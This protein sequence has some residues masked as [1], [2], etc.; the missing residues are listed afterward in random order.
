LE[1]NPA[2]LVPRPETE[3]V[4]ESAL[5][6]VGGRFDLNGPLRMA[7]LGT[8]SGALLAALLTEMPAAHSVG[9]DLS[10]AALVCPRR[11]PLA[12][13]LDRRAMFVA[14]GYASALAGPFELI[15]SN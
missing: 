14:C 12:L 15:V 11:N 3:T 10:H 4:V 2:T 7:D 8:G 1:L 13:A 6:A 9:T 5:A